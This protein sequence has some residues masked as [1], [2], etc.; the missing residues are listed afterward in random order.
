MYYLS[1]REVLIRNTPGTHDQ[2]IPANVP[3]FVCP[4]LHDAANAAGCVP[5]EED[6]SLVQPGASAP[7]TEPDK[8]SDPVSNEDEAAV[9]LEFQTTVQG[10]DDTILKTALTP[11]M[12]DPRILRLTWD[13]AAEE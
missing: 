2:I 1:L 11:L 7:V 4:P 8:P 10:E 5:C 12:V 6:G 13:R 9:M 3:T